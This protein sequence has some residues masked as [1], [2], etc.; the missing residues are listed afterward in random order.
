R[1]DPEVRRHAES[2]LA[3]LSAVLPPE[4]RTAVA[5]WRRELSFSGPGRRVDEAVL[6]GLRVG[7]QERR[8]VRL[9]YSGR[10][11]ATAEEREV[12]PISLVY[13]DERWYLAAY[14]RAR[15]APRFFRLDRIDQFRVLQERFELG[16]RHDRPPEEH[17]LSR[18]RPGALEAR[19]RFDPGVIRRVRE[20]NLYLF[21]REEVDARGPIFVYRLREDHDQDTLLHWLLGWGATAE[22]LAPPPLR[23]RLAAE[24]TVVAERHA[25]PLDGEHGGDPTRPHTLRS[26]SSDGTA[27]GN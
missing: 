6:G 8:V 7:V 5:R 25:T 13:L 11:R 22:V 17:T 14:C 15:Q 2:V 19:V 27:A 1:V 4:K 21:L 26:A 18:D 10:R 24:A 9:R 3:K 23:A 12:E 20:Q 16:P